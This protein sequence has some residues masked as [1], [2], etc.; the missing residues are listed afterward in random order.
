MASS[1]SSAASVDK[2]PTKDVLNF[3]QSSTTLNSFLAEHSAIPTEVDI[4]LRQSAFAQLKSIVSPKHADVKLVLVPTGSYGLGVWA[5][6]C[7]I[8]CL[9]IGSI[10]TSVFIQLARQRLKKAAT[11]GV[12]ILRTV[13]SASGTYFE[14]EIQGV[15]LNLQYCPAT[16]VVETWPRI[17]QASVSDS[18]FDLPVTSRKKLN[19]WRDN[20]YLTHSIPDIPTFWLAHRFLRLWAAKRG[21][22]SA[23][24]GY[25][26]SFHLSLMLSRVCKLVSRDKGNPTAPD[27]VRTFFN[28]YATFD[29]AVHMVFDPDVHA[30]K[31]RYQRTSREHLVILTLHAPVIN[32]AYSISMNSLPTLVEELKRADRLMSYEDA[33]WSD[34]IS[35][36]EV[37]N[38]HEA[39]RGG[40]VDFIKAF[41]SYVKIEI[42]YWGASSAKASTLLEWLATKCVTFNSELNTKLPEIYARLWPTRFADVGANQGL[43]RDHRAFYLVGLALSRPEM[44]QHP[45]PKDDPHNRA[46]QKTLQDILQR[47]T[48]QIRGD[49][50][51]YDPTSSWMDCT[52]IRQ[53]DIGAVKLDDRE[54][55]RFVI[56]DDEADNEDAEKD[57]VDSD[58][59]SSNM[60]F[61]AGDTIF[62]K[63]KKKSS[64]SRNVKPQPV[65][66][67]GKLRPAVDILNRLRW[68]PTVDESD[69]LV[70]YEDRFLGIREIPLDRWKGE[71][72]DDEF[73]PQHRI[74]HFKR[75]SDGEVVWE[76]E[77]K[78]DKVFGSGAT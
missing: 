24:F 46:I 75:K 77:R 74:M 28:H 16:E 42:H 44:P 37:L 1:T 8:D 15:L 14:L 26:S 29:F 2:I 43:D 72:T 12:R 56:D 36:G 19:A 13:K 69:Y 25:L 3:L 51:S 61:E 5:V 54:W 30:P 33:S 57:D 4:A 11:Q 45:V 68:D 63:P 48:E 53:A 58:E 23:K 52:V 59:D 41:K 27:I 50:R 39:L 21:I 65:V 9:C 47:F 38:P 18:M 66:I 71:Q 49:E 62:K 76:K 55:G 67:A 78:L 7:D 35:S 17:N 22:L 70:G 32:A 6:S 40:P 73:I 34:L 20:Y 60:T 31:P 10:S 64:P